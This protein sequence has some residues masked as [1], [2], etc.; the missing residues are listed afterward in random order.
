MQSTRVL[1]L[2]RSDPCKQTYLLLMNFLL[3]AGVSAA[4]VM[5]LSVSHAHLPAKEITGFDTAQ[6]K[7]MGWSITDDGVMGGLSKGRVSFS[8]GVMKFQGTLS[9]RNNGGF[10]TV[11]SKRIKLDLSDH[12][13]LKL[14]VKGDGR[15]YQVRLGTDARYR[16]MEVTFMA[17]FK[18]KKGKWMEVNVP[19]SAFKAGFRGRSLPDVTLDTAKIRRMGILLGDK[20]EGPFEVSVDWLKAN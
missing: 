9:L 13:G 14:R 11:R 12:S 1:A 2:L 8:S 17:E 5:M 6:N 7:A 18:T 20:K 3:G 15:S 10:S 4:F 16:G 19:F